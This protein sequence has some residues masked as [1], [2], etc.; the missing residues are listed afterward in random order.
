MQDFT[1]SAACFVYSLVIWIV[2]KFMVTWPPI[3]WMLSD[4]VPESSSSYS[5]EH[6][7]TTADANHLHKERNS[8][9]IRSTRI[10]CVLVFDTSLACLLGD[11]AT[12]GS[13]FEILD[14]K[15]GRGIF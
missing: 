10:L 5:N 2:L 1:T 11:L 15:L 14:Q 12:L 7:D 4:P 3:Q 13:G 9:M 8:K 6:E